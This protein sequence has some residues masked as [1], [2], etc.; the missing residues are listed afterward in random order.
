MVKA[1][2][3]LFNRE[4][5]PGLARAAGFAQPLEPDGR[6]TR[7]A[8]FEDSERFGIVVGEQEGGD[9]DLALAIG[10]KYSGAR[11][12][13]LVLPRGWEFPTVQRVAWLQEDAQ[14]EVYVHDGASAEKRSIPS[15]DATVAALVDRL[16]DVTPKVEL[17]RA[18]TPVH[19]ATSSDVVTDLVEWATRHSQLDHGHRRGERSWHCLGQRVLSIRSTKAGLSIRA[20][21]HT[22]DPTP[23]NAPVVLPAG[24]A[25]SRDKLA[26]IMDRVSGAIEA[27]LALGGEYHRPDEHWLQAVLRRDPALVGIEQPALREVPAWRPAPAG[28]DGKPWS[29]GFID[30]VGLDGQGDIRIVETKLAKNPD[31][32]LVFQGL[33]YYRWACAYQTAL[34]ERLGASPHSRLVVHYV[35]GATQPDDRIHC[36]HHLAAQIDALHSDFPWRFQELRGWYH[37]PM[38]PIGG[39]PRSTLLPVG[40]LPAASA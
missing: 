18:M 10:I 1:A 35:V 6:S 8:Y 29:R 4:V 32:L 25:L 7:F 19:L 33:D 16:H 2:R 39:V 13:V 3:E 28:T 9:A 17:A 22:K 40:Q 14:S 27:R 30:L 11:R 5:A 20:G 12:L 34:R 23:D 37:G 38:S 15:R 36:S 24:D 31:D 21:I 26:V